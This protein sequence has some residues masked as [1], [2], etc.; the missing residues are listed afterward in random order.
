MERVLPEE[1]TVYF[2]LDNTLAL[3]S[4]RK[5]D[6]KSLKKMY[7]KGFYENL[8]EVFGAS[9]VVKLLRYVGVNVKIISG[10]IDSPYVEV[11][12][13]TWCHTHLDMNWEDVYLLDKDES[14]AEL[15]GNLTKNDMLVDDWYRYVDEWRDAGG[16]GVLMVRKGE[17][18]PGYNCMFSLMDV[19]DYVEKRIELSECMHFVYTE[20]CY[21][22]KEKLWF[23]TKYPILGRISKWV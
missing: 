11:E 19:L 23:R 22:L 12:K 21:R 14:K 1:L 3:W 5:T 17:P 15:V 20:E 18:I 9:E 7:R 4:T 6:K 8:P 13:L 16:D 2:D 10:L